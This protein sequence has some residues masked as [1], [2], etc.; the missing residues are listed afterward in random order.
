MFDIKLE[1][2]PECGG[3]EISRLNSDADH[4][5]VGNSFP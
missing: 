2:G 4:P 3:G 1:A 5:T